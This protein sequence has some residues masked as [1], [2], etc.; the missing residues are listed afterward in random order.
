MSV[1]LILCVLLSAAVAVC[2]PPG[3]SA[4]S[5]CRPEAGPGTGS[6]KA[7][8]TSSGLSPVSLSFTWTWSASCDDLGNSPVYC[9]WCLVTEVWVYSDLQWMPASLVNGGSAIYSKSLTTGCGGEALVSFGRAVNFSS[10]ADSAYPTT[11]CQLTY[12]VYKGI[13]CPPPAGASPVS[14]GTLE[15]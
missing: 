11:G 13:I 8:F 9:C 10:D 14:T 2:P 12:A 15:W 5:A 6:I 3:W 1:R 4:P 7:T